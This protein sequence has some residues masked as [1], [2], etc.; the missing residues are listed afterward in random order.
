MISIRKYMPRS[1]F[2][3]FILIFTAPVLAVQIVAIYVF[4]Y[5][6]ADLMNKNIS[7]SIAAEM[8]HI[9][10]SIL[11]KKPKAQVDDFARLV[12][13]DYYI[14]QGVA[15]NMVKFDDS[16]WRRNKIYQY[17][18][19]F[20][21]IDPL[22]R[23][24]SEMKS[25]GLAPFEIYK[26]QDNSDIFV[27]RVKNKNLN[28]SFDILV[29]RVHSSSKYVFILWMI[30]TA[31]IT[32]VVA[33]IFLKNQLRP[34]KS[35]TEAAKDIGQGRDIPNLKPA[36]SQELR[37]LILEFSR[38]AGRV[39]NYISQRTDMLSGVSHDLRTPLTR[40]KLSLEMSSDKALAKDLRQDIADMETLIEEYLDF[41]KNQGREKFKNVDIH[42]YL[43]EE[44]KAPYSKVASNVN[45]DIQI[46]IGTIGH[47]KPTSYK[48][49]V[50]N[51]IDNGLKYG[52]NVQIL[53]KIGRKKLIVVVD[54]D[55]PGISK[56]KRRKVFEPFYREDESR[57]LDASSASSGLGMS[58]AEDGVVSHGGKIKLSESDAGGLRV[59][60]FIPF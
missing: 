32:S 60:I 6:Y 5:F 37:S 55:G 49:A 2:G 52:V 36:G 27:V 29:K 47:I 23:L 40:M 25:K 15:K 51:I 14:N 24:K 12:D 8:S 11:A 33:I 53:A 42:K 45:F 28:V 10:R 35:L 44:I 50:T 43:H 56:E 13:I 18:N 39:R 46:P 41:A 48:R 4:F 30:F 17:V 7:R 58:I 3:R 54:D 38:M 21:I 22:N 1:L 9:N 31:L 34:L 57:N 16:R 26:V 19:L 20:P 59:M